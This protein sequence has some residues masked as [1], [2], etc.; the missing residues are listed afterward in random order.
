[1][2]SN[3]ERLINIFADY[4]NRKHNYNE[5]TTLLQSLCHACNVPPNFPR[6]QSFH[7]IVIWYEAVVKWL[8]SAGILQ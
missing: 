5:A 8:V 3:I 7:N 6:Y 4:Y 1:M 2:S